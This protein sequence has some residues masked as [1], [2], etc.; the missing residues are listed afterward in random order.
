M[1]RD[2][3]VSMDR[4]WPAPGRL[5]S[6]LGLSA[7]ALALLAVRGPA[8]AD[9]EPM[10]PAA[11]TPAVKPTPFDP[12]YVL[13]SMSGVVLFRPAAAFGKPGMPHYAQML[14]ALCESSLATELKV[15][16]SKPDFPKLG[17]EDIEW[18][19]AGLDIGTPGSPPKT[20]DPAPMHS[21]VVG[22][23]T[24]RATH[25][26][27]W[28]ALLRAWRFT[29]EELHEDGRV[30]YKIG[31]P[32]RSLFGPRDGCVYLPDD[33]TLVFNELSAVRAAVRRG[34]SDRFDL[35]PAEHAALAAVVLTNRDD[36]FTRKYDIGRKGADEVVLS[37]LRQADRWSIRVDDVDSISLSGAIECRSHENAKGLVGELLALSK[38]SDQLGDDPAT[39]AEGWRRDAILRFRASLANLKAAAEGSRVEVS[40]GS[41]GTFSWFAPLVEN[42]LAGANAPQPQP[43]RAEAITRTPPK[44]AEP[45]KNRR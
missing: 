11:P 38:L 12:S 3:A 29:F 36:Q 27:D 1:L 2:D 18:V 25:P 30:F 15:D 31:E 39:V 17:L 40:T 6:A 5:L 20:T 26:V 16:P 19:V 41:L 37:H 21:L 22:G 8:R 43:A 4:T 9:A 14:R 10:P 7:V 32:L 44:L 13:D 42:V 24:V 34:P 33:R 23:L 35:S 28:L 45:E